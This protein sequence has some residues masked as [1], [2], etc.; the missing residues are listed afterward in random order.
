[1][2]VEFELTD[3]DQI[4]FIKKNVCNVLGR[5]R[6]WICLLNCITFYKVEWL[7]SIEF[8]DEKKI[9]S[10]Y[11]VWRNKRKETPVL[12]VYLQVANTYRFK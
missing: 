4:L 8:L 11:L 1:M 12:F 9:S 2:G 6:V 7:T 10:F 3:M 5:R